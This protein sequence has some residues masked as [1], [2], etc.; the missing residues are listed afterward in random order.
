MSS[1]LDESQPNPHPFLLRFLSRL[2]RPACAIV[3][4]RAAQLNVLAG[5][6]IPAV[7][8]GLDVKSIPIIGGED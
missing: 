8:G 2:Q 1:A 5:Q 4:D 3:Y 7:R 6:T